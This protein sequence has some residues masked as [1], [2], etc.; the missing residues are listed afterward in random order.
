L[1]KSFTSNQWNT[2]NQFLASGTNSRD[3]GIPERIAGSIVFASWNIR[4]FGALRDKQGELKKSQ[5]ASELIAKFCRQCDLIAIQE[6]QAD[7]EAVFDLKDRLNAAGGSYKIIMSDVTGQAPGARGSPERFAFLYNSEIISIGTLAS[8][9]SFDRSA[10]LKKVKA[11]YATS[12]SA[13]LPKKSEPGF[14]ERALKWI[15]DIPRIVNIRIKTFVEF[16]RAPHMVEFIVTGPDGKYEIRC[17]NAHLVSGSS[18]TERSNEFFALLEWLIIRSKKVVAADKKIIMLMADLNLDFESNLDKRKKGIEEYITSLNKSRK[19]DA[20][21]NFPFL[22]GGFFTNARRNKTFDHIAFI[23]DDTRWPRGRHNDLAGTLGNDQFDYGMF[24][25]TKLFVEAGPGKL[26]DGQP[27]Y[28]RFA[29]D[30]TD[31]L[32]IWVRMPLPSTGQHLFEVS[33][34]PG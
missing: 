13:E 28:D 33:E 10:V 22:D 8:D 25:F 20:K 26:P 15:T 18:K 9:L 14:V 16:I 30:F 3:L 5:G 24:N 34:A 32:P 1:A 27:D 12:L 7:S 21:V 19:M 6:V 4:K 31:H 17:I 11:A 23:A 2:I 29:H